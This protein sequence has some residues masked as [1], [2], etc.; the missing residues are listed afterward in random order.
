M[1]TLAERVFGDIGL[2]T[3]SVASLLHPVVELILLVRVDP[4]GKRLG[5]GLSGQREQAYVK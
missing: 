4:T 1:K 5:P 3:G 2:P